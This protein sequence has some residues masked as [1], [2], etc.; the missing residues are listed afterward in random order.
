M[1]LGGGVFLVLVSSLLITN[2]LVAVR[3]DALQLWFGVFG[4][5]VLAFWLVSVFIIFPHV[6]VEEAENQGMIGERVKRRM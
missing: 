1:M 3:V 2:L 6:F 5:F 4:M